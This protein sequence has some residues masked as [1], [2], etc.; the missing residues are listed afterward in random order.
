LASDVLR[1]EEGSPGSH[2]CSDLETNIVLDGV[3]GILDASS[4]DEP[5]LVDSIMAV[6]PCQ[7][8]IVDIPSSVDIKALSSVVQN[9]SS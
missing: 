5:G 1:P 8:L 2:L 9:V 4:V 3:G 6:P 7:V